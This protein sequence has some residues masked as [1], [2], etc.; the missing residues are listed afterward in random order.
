MM[1]SIFTLRALAAE[2][3]DVLAGCAIADAWSQ[4]RGEVIV[5]VEGRGQLH[6]R[7]HGPVQCTFR[8]PQASRARRN[9]ATVLAQAHGQSIKSV[10]VA[11]GDRIL[12]MAL[13]EGHEL[14][15]F[16][17]GSR[18]NVFL[19]RA[20]GKVIEAFRRGANWAGRSLPAPQEAALPETPSEF[21]ARWKPANLSAA[22][23]LGRAFKVFDRTLVL[24]AM[25]RAG[26]TD[27]P[28]GACEARDLEAL[29]D[30]MQEIGRA[31]ER[32]R[33]RVYVEANT[34]S[35]IPLK[36]HADTEA[37]PYPSVDSALRAWAK[38]ALAQHALASL[39]GPLQ[40]V[41]ARALAKARRK[42]GSLRAELQCISRAATYERYGHLLMARP[43][44]PAGARTIVLDDI[45]SGQDTVTIP[46]QPSLS[47]IE[48]AQRY[49]AK[50]R[51]ARQARHA[52]AQQAQEAEAWA[53]RLIA[54]LE[55]VSAA[56]S[57][58]DV[59][60]LKVRESATLAALGSQQQVAKR[61]PYRTYPLA[62]GYEVRVGKNARDSDA[63]TLRHARPFDLWMHARGTSGAHAVL[64]LPNRMAQPGTE[65]LNAAASLAAYHSKA[66]GSAF[67]P[68]IVTPRKYVRKPKGAEP[69]SV[70]VDQ[71]EVLI[72]KPAL[73]SAHA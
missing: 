73:P 4:H 23:A 37:R 14:Q 8:S 49:Y 10:R 61:L 40:K 69:G 35:L 29:F 33:P 13:E 68:V 54:L 19:T 67:V 17:F 45:I 27:K 20:N 32:P 42:A 28:A 3:S 72:V 34:F 41:V 58:A 65:L 21:L 26:V 59:K 70:V 24:E 12:I 15:A 56:N 48:N 38:R 7:L 2:W 11:P 52:L 31:L 39:R 66:R 1:N 36:T 22:R 62:P 50:A 5:A 18:A 44:Q 63:L 9:V 43:P 55:E 6:L 16:L 46:L 47:T 64:R 30:S 25:E 60:A 57:V 53:E 71:E 51:K